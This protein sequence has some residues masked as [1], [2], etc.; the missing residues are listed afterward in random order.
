MKGTN[1][2][3][4]RDFREIADSYLGDELAV[5]TNHDVIRHLEG[6]GDC[7]RELAA[8]REVRVKLKAA[9]A[10]AP[11]MQV[12]PEFAGRLRTRLQAATRSEQG[13]R[14]GHRKAWIALAASLSIA[15]ALSLAWLVRE[16]LR[17]PDPREAT[18]RRTAG[19]TE[20]STPPSPGPDSGMPVR[21]AKAELAESAAG[22]HQN[23]AV[24]FRL[25]ERPIDLDEAGRRYDRVYLDLTKAV[26]SQQTE[27][28]EFVEAHSCV[29]QGRRFAHIVLKYHG[30][31]VSFLVT[32]LDRSDKSSAGG[33]RTLTDP[34]R[35][36]IACS[37]FEGYQVSCFET[38][39]HA[40]FVVSDL[41]ET[42]NLA[43]ARSL[44]PS[45]YKQIVRNESAT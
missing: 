18:V 45:A 31:L 44:A 32:D 13:G 23:C 41:S 36:V 39:R 21:I 17:R 22:D 20:P 9:F 8:R 2:M 37:Q 3:R 1:H 42:E 19:G 6:C 4:C 7:R 30:R 24:K 43:L 10:G 25:S 34:D 5:E 40:V 33:R 12:R 29:Y 38:P 15:A 26:L 27:P 35:Q 28:V 14:F 16:N 11:E